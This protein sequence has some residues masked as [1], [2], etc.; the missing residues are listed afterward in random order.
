DQYESLAAAGLRAVESKGVLLRDCMM[1]VD[2]NTDAAKNPCARLVQAK[3]SG[4]SL[5]RVSEAIDARL[6][7]L[8]AHSSRPSP[9]ASSQFA[10][11]LAEVALPEAA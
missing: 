9:A 6:A 1:G 7:S 5:T 4:L 2:A 3:E 8:A 10:A 11:P